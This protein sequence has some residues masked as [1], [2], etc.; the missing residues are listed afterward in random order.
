[1]NFVCLLHISVVKENKMFVW[2]IMGY[3]RP[4][5]SENFKN[6]KVVY[7]NKFVNTCFGQIS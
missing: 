7:T 5:M 4:C 6:T 2:L 1:M 3:E